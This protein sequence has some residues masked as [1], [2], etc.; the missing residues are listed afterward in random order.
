M[1][2]IL[3][4]ALSLT[5]IFSVLTGV[6]Y[7]LAMTGLSQSLF[8]NSANGSMVQVSGKVIGSFLIGQNFAADTYFHGR[9]SAAGKDG[10]DATASSG[11]NLGPSSKALIDAVKQRVA[12]LGGGPVPDDLVLASASG[13]DP[14][15]SPEGALFQVARVAKARNI[16]EAKVK[17]LVMRVV[18]QPQFGVLGEPRVN[19]L[20]LNL[21]LDRMTISP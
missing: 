20:G 3:R 21:A 16:D 11:S 14:D 13:L 5:V 4:P 6:A 15:I 8:P 19:V 1:T 7:P 18:R 9:P 10:Y 17:A 12:D 2:N